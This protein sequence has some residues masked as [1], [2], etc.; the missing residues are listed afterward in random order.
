M[1]GA[2]HAAITNNN[3]ILFFRVV[4]GFSSGCV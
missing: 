2:A 1:S 3:V 4:A